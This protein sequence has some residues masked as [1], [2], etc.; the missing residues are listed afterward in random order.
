MGRGVH[1]MGEGYA[2]FMQKGPSNGH[3]SRVSLAY[4]RL[5]SQKLK[6][7]SFQAISMLSY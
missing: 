4:C 2:Y 5:I 7:I 3:I 1:S 6:H